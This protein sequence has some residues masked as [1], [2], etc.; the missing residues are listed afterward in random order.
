MLLL[1][2]DLLITLNIINIYRFYNIDLN[3]NLYLK[4]I[5]ILKEH[6]KLY[7]KNLLK[8]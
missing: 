7:I 5:N 6:E 4:K 1:L 3:F 8:S 2:T